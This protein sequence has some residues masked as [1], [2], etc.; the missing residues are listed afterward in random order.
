MEDW[1]E[2]NPGSYKPGEIIKGRAGPWLVVADE[3][4]GCGPNSQRAEIISQGG[5]KILKLRTDCT[6]IWI[7][8]QDISIPIEPGVNLS[9]SGTADIVDPPGRFSRRIAGLGLL[10]NA[11][12]G[13]PASS[14][15]YA[16]YHDQESGN[17][18][19]PY[20]TQYSVEQLNGAE[21]IV[22]NVFEDFSEVINFTPD[23]AK[24]SQ[25][26][27]ILEAGGS[28]TLRSV[29]ISKDKVL[30]QLERIERIPIYNQ[31]KPNDQSVRVTLAPSPL[32]AGETVTLKLRTI[33]GDGSAVFDNG[34][35]TMIISQSTTV[36]I[37]G[38]ANSTQKNNI[39]LAAI[40]DGEEVNREVFSVRTWPTNF[41]QKTG[42]DNGN[43]VIFFE[44][45]WDPESGKP[46]DLAG[47]IVGEI[48]DYNCAEGDCFTYNGIPVFQPPSPPYSGNFVENP[49]IE[50]F[51]ITTGTAFPDEH[52]F[53][54]WTPFKK[55]YRSHVF[56]A[57]Q[58]YRFRDPVLMDSGT[59]IDLMGPLSI[60][61]EVF[62]DNGLWKY[63]VEKSGVSSEL[64]LP[65]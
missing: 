49:Q 52:K 55:P 1:E 63:R 26:A 10:D 24:V 59:Y 3:D 35:E 13:N 6:G 42:R 64:V 25:V 31:S 2:A 27:F 39:E 30:V 58:F 54:S 7:V 60:R 33:A 65:E 16:L 50:E 19:L 4:P 62:E 47:I 48:V 5:K 57:T 61:R 28:A 8:N 9:F 40:H 21:L 15:V 20:F 46:S 18:C 11:R 51:A 45:Q 56:T 17:I 37:R 32:P 29:E 14:V 36:Q 41:R 38:T 22:R 12:N 44:Y 23:G 34:S 53:D 43:G